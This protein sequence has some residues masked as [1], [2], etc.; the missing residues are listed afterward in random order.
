MPQFTDGGMQSDNISQNS[1][2]GPKESCWQCYKL[3][4]KG[5]AVVC[6]IADKVSVFEANITLTFYRDF[7]S[8]SVF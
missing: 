3:Y 8:K 5:E 4:P 7:V 2:F 1:K 6:E